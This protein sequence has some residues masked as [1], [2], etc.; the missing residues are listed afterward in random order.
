M[1]CGGSAGDAVDNVGQ[2]GNP[3]ALAVVRLVHKDDP[4]YHQRDVDKSQN[5]IEQRSQSMRQ[6]CDEDAEDDGDSEPRYREANRLTSVK[7]DVLVLVVR[8]E[9][10]END[11][12]DEAQQVRQRGNNVGLRFSVITVH[13]EFSFSSRTMIPEEILDH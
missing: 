5:E 1:L 13:R 10:Q 8:L 3:V 7:T 4:E 9:V 6:H 2:L 12:G 11:A